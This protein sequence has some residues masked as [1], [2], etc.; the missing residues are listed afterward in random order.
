ML[1]DK[2]KAM[3]L[4]AGKKRKDMAEALNMKVSGCDYWLKHASGNIPRF[5]DFCKLC[6]FKVQFRSRINSKDVIN[7]TQADINEDEKVQLRKR[8]TPNAYPKK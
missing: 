1:E 5:F 3:L 4:S 2:I 7:I 6:G 8:H